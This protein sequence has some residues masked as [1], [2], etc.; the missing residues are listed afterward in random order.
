MKPFAM[1]VLASVFEVSWDTL[2][3]FCIREYPE[4]I[5]WN[6]FIV[7]GLFCEN[8]WILERYAKMFYNAFGSFLRLS[9]L[10]LFSEAFGTNFCEFCNEVL[11]NMMRRCAKRFFDVVFSTFCNKI[12]QVMYDEVSCEKY[13]VLYCEVYLRFR[14][15]FQSFLSFL[16]FFDSI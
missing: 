7:F 13:L 6:K 16:I 11:V 8:F 4:V 5:C 10:I 15:L 2:S 14:F 12:F 3:L 1:I 9:I